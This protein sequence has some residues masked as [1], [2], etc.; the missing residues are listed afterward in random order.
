MASPLPFSVY[1]TVNTRMTDKG[2]ARKSMPMTLAGIL[3]KMTGQNGADWKTEAGG[4]LV[5]S[6]RNKPTF[7]SRTAIQV[8]AR[9]LYLAD[10]T[11]D[12]EFR[13]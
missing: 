11:K 4:G 10:S 1:Q 3:F 2:R 9:I 13:G 6:R 12:G 8:P 7:L 5:A